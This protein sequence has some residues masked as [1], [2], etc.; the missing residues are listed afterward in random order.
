ML[1][2]LDIIIPVYNS[3]SILADLIKRLNE[4]SESVEIKIR[5]F[6]IDDGSTDNSCEIIKKEQ[7]YFEC[8]LIRLAR[9]YGQHTATAFGLGLSNAPLVATIDDDLQHDPFELNKLID[10]IQ[11]KNVDLVF[12]SYNKKEHSLLRNLGSYLLKKIFRVEGVDYSGVTSFRLMKFSVTK[13]FNN[14]KQPIVFIEEYL[15]KNSKNVAVC[16]VKHNK[17]AIG[18]SSY[19]NWALFKF[20]LKIVLFHSS[21]PLKFTTRFG[22]LMSIVFFSIGSY[23][24]Y[25]KVFNDVQIGFTSIIVAIFFSTGILL[26]SI[27]VIGEYIR[28]IWVSQNKVDQLVVLEQE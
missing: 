19:S 11:S 3:Q 6:F 23:Y 26:M 16:E 5:V 18:K 14:L 8:K 20:A 2:D 7:K 9:N 17:R 10:C 4:W 1:K 22:L 21:F 28:K 27:G 13:Q 24:I 25:D 12:G 15:F